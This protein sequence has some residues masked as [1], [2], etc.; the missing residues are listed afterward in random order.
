MTG[1][2]NFYHWAKCSACRDA[3]KAVSKTDRSVH[4]RDFFKDPLTREE[5]MRISALASVDEM[6]SWKSP[7]AAPY[8]ERRGQLSDDELISLMLNEPRLIRRPILVTGDAVLF[9]YRTKEYERALK[10]ER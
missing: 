4:E 5:I 7:S 3:R 8:R 2:I 6:F 9:G 1:D 10:K